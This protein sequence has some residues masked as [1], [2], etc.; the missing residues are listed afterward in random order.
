MSSKKQEK[1]KTAMLI[2]TDKYGK[3]TYTKEFPASCR[4]PAVLQDL[5]RM[6]ECLVVY[7]VSKLNNKLTFE[8]LEQFK[9]SRGSDCKC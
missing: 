7:P 2:I 5:E 1:T 4:R 3:L 8:G 6:A 9:D